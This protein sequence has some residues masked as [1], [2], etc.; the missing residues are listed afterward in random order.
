MKTLKTIINLLCV[1]CLLGVSY[2]QSEITWKKSINNDDSASLSFNTVKSVID[3]EGYSYT[4]GIFRSTIDLDPNQE[5]L[6]LTPKGRQ[7]IFIQKL[8]TNGNLVWAISYG[9]TEET[10]Y[11]DEIKLDSQGNIFVK[12]YFSGTVDFDPSDNEFNLTSKGET[13]HYILKLNNNGEFLWAQAFGTEHSDGGG[14]IAFDSENSVIITG[15]FR[16]TIDINPGGGV[17]HITS[18]G[19]HPIFDLANTFI[20]K[21]H[22]SGNFLW[23]R[24]VTST[25]TCAAQSIETDSKGNIVIAG[26]F[27]GKTDFDPGTNVYELEQAKGFH[28]FLLKLNSAGDFK[29]VKNF[30]HKTDSFLNTISSN[31]L[32]IDQEDNL[33]WGA[34]YRGSI[35]ID[36]GNDEYILPYKGFSTNSFIVKLTSQG[37]FLWG[38]KIG[39]RNEYVSGLST[40]TYG[41]IYATGFLLDEVKYDLDSRDDSV[42]E[43]EL[44]K[45]GTGSSYCIG[46]NGKDGVP[47]FARLLEGEFEKEY[48]ENYRDDIIGRSISINKNNELLFTSVAYSPTNLYSSETTVNNPNQTDPEFISKEEEEGIIL[49]KLNIDELQKNLSKTFAQA[50]AEKLKAYPNPIKNDNQ[51]IVDLGSI[52]D[53][54]I[55][56]A[57]LELYDFKGT[58]L[59]TIPASRRLVDLKDI[60]HQL[61]SGIYTII[62]KSTNQTS[63]KSLKLIK[64]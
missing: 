23:A 39:E 18:L 20:L 26:Y 40:D 14:D 16:G 48:E 15:R 35:D 9:G 43:I 54:D 58:L 46:Y 62:L 55:K 45:G 27:D 24:S 29:W 50:T 12:G 37:S 3:N 1:F 61:K 8:D 31:D 56:N 33:I 47:F 64:I 34:N 38:N 7:D 32:I 42:F 41:N 4:I 25:E 13:D 19:E 51:V 57:I 59:K 44:Q 52:N 2:A 49:V 11:F 6:E 21:L 63:K 5:V 30:K 36:P 17:Y 10:T 28:G 60:N 53:K 22:S